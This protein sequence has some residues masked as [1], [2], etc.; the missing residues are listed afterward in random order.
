MKKL[1]A[2]VAAGSVAGGLGVPVLAATTRT[3]K[4][5]DNYFVRSGARPTVS[6]RKG[7][8]VKWVW[9]GSAAHN[10]SVRRGPQRFSSPVKVRGSYSHRMTRRGTYRIVCT[11]HPG[12]EMTLKV[13]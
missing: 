10:V 6:V 9:R 11:I 1:V 4:V 2:L 7:T 3:V 13:T 12:M 8:T 5:G